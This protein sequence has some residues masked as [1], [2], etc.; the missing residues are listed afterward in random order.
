MR[1]LNLATKGADKDAEGEAILGALSDPSE[2]GAEL[3]R[4]VD[5]LRRLIGLFNQELNRYASTL[6]PD[7]IQN[8]ERMSTAARAAVT[9]IEAEQR[10]PYSMRSLNEV[11]RVLVDVRD[12]YLM[13][14]GALIE[15][16]KQVEKRA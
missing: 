12:A 3:K 16:A 8:M 4:R 14:H 6:H 9:S 5:R 15:R 11:R 1:D 2:W 13:L 10:L 7:V